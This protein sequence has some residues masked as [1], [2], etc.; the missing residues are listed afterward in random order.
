MPALRVGLRWGGAAVLAALL[1][2]LVFMSPG[3]REFW[4]ILWASARR[5]DIGV[6]IPGANGFDFAAAGLEPG[7]I[8]LGAN[9]GNSW[10]HWTHAALYVGNGQVVDTLLRYGV[11]LSP[12]ER[13]AHAYQ[14]AGVL[15]VNLP[16]DVKARA[17]A[18]ALGTLG[19][20]FNLLAG[21]ETGDWFYCTKLAWWVYWRAGYDLD[22]DGGHWVVPDR[23]LASPAVTLTASPPPP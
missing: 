10:G 18:L 15:K 12:V 1:H 5:G 6:G 4:G 23:F 17:V 13:F 7:D 22:P 20:P 8:V 14:Q 21:R 11:H 2:N 9:P 19:R 3:T 16:P